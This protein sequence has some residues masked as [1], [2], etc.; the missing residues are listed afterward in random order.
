MQ[1]SQGGH[2]HLGQNHAAAVR[3]PEV[4]PLPLTD[5]EDR[6]EVYQPLE[7]EEGGL[8]L[9]EQAKEVHQ[10]LVGQAPSGQA[11]LSLSR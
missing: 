7:Q 8:L 10:P 2:H 6:E 4:W 9:V 11:L 3:G 5:E 1:N